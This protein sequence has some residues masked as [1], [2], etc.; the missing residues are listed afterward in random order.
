MFSNFSL[1]FVIRSLICGMMAIVSSNAFLYAHRT[2]VIV[3]VYSIGFLN[4]LAQISGSGLHRDS[5]ISSCFCFGAVYLPPVSMSTHGSHRCHSPNSPTSRFVLPAEI[6]L[7][8][9][10]AP[11]LEDVEETRLQFGFVRVPL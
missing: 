10:I 2:S 6:V 5:R 7:C 8:S 11:L 4:V 1:A 3:T 9:M